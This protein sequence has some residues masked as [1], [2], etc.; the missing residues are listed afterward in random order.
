VGLWHAGPPLLDCLAGARRTERPTHGEHSPE[1]SSP[2]NL[3]DAQTAA[4]GWPVEGERIGAERQWPNP[5]FH[6]FSAEKFGSPPVAGPTAFTTCAS[7]RGASATFLAAHLSRSFFL[8]PFL[9]PFIFPFFFPFSYFLSFFLSFFLFFFF[10]FIQATPKSRLCP[11]RPRHRR[12]RRRR[13]HH[14]L[15]L[16]FHFSFL[17]LQRKQRE[18]R[19]EQRE[20]RDQRRQK[21]PPA[22]ALPLFTSLRNPLDRVILSANPAPLLHYA[23]YPAR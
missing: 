10:F 6:R 2:F 18:Q 13:R 16:Y 1:P 14:L 8:L 4:L 9:F 20:Q 23:K 15:A 7:M 11:R 5:A 19:E 3:S 17:L 22:T 21:E 12:R